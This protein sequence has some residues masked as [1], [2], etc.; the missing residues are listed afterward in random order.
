[1]KKVY[2]SALDL[3]SGIR[4]WLK[5][6][7]HTSYYTLPTSYLAQQHHNQALFSIRTKTDG[8]EN[9]QLQGVRPNWSFLNL[10]PDVTY[11]APYILELEYIRQSGLGL[12]RE[13]LDM[14]N[15]LFLVLVLNYVTNCGC[16]STRPVP[17]NESNYWMDHLEEHTHTLD[18]AGFEGI[19]TVKELVEG[20]YK[21][22]FEPLET[23]TRTFQKKHVRIMGAFPASL[24]DV[25]ETIGVIHDAEDGAWGRTPESAIIGQ[26]LLFAPLALTFYLLEKRSGIYEDISWGDYQEWKGNL[27]DFLDPEEY[28]RRRLLHR[29]RALFTREGSNT[30]VDGDGDTLHRFSYGYVDYRTDYS[31]TEN[32]DQ[33]FLLWLFDQ[34]FRTIQEQGV[35]KAVT[36]MPVKLLE[37]RKKNNTLDGVG[38]IRLHL[39][40]KEL[41]WKSE[42]E[43]A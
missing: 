21:E 2:V 16:D 29:D 11:T 23:S 26:T 34:V 7:N 5:A 24:K 27:P 41:Q 8:P 12:T 37:Q 18:P 4:E 3:L 36:E 39:N 30:P 32:D 10:D 38:K 43:E 25:F 31:L 1:M 13:Q 20:V 14:L 42:E 35:S 33:A 40:Y 9:A 28:R 6:K 19:K 17:M 15:Q 22:Q